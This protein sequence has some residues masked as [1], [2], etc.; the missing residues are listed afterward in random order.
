V[1][2]NLRAYRS[3]DF[4]VL[5]QVDRQCY[6]PQIAYTRGDL[7]QY[8]RH[9]GAACVVAEADGKIVGF[10]IAASKQGYGYIITMDVLENYRRHGIA[11]ALLTDIEE[12]L[13]GQGARVIGLET[14]TDNEAGIAFWERHG[15][16]KRRVRKGYYPGGRDAYTMSKDLGASPAGRRN[17]AC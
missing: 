13:S 3:S 6:V 1:I 11:S 5:Y 14:A 4:E 15:Y 12:K 7:R 8:L 17:E 2:F 10:C 9:P 16:R